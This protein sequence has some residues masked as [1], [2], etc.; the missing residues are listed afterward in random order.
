MA[1]A[2]VVEA[3]DVAHLVAAYPEKGAAKINRHVERF[4]AQQAGEVTCLASWD[5]TGPVG[6]VFVSWPGGRCQ[7][8]DIAEELQ[9]AEIGDLKVAEIARGRGIGRKLMEVA[10]AL[11]RERGVSLV[12]LRVTSHDPKQNA[13]RALYETLGFEDGGYGEFLSGYTYLDREGN[14]HRDEELYRYLVKKL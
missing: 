6:Y 7:R 12:G 2:R 4:E 10:E 9:C 11:V 8:T 3:A 13:A 5:D 1:V 14:S